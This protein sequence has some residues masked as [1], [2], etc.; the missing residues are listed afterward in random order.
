MTKLNSDIRKKLREFKN[1]DLADFL[2]DTKCK[3][4]NQERWF[5]DVEPLTWK[6]AYCGNTAFYLYGALRQQIEVLASSPEN[7]KTF[8][9]KE[10]GK[11]YS[12]KKNE[13]VKM[14]NFKAKARC[15]K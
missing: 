8:V 1:K 10:D 14:L 6:C 2:P 11:S 7:K 15:L 4:C 5:A 3:K 9:A 12:A 13:D